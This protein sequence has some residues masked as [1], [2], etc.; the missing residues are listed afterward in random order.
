MNLPELLREHGVP[1]RNA[2]EHHHVT[3]GWLGADC[4]FCSPNSG[5]F[6]LGI[7]LD[8]LRCSCWSC[9]WHPT[10]P[11]LAEL[12]GLP[13]H[14][15]RGM[16]EGLDTPRREEEVHGKLVLPEG[17]GALLPAHRDYLAGRGIDPDDAGD[18][19]GCR[20]LGIAPRLQWRVWIP[21]R[22]RGKTAS[23][24]TRSIAENPKLRYV[25][26]R[27]EQES[28]SL[29]S[30]LLGEE[31]CSHAILVVE[32]PLDAMILGPGAVSTS[33]LTITRAQVNRMAKYPVRVI[34]LDAEPV[35]Q[36]VARKLCRALGA[37]PGQ[38]FNICLESGKDPGSCS[39]R[40]RREI[41]RRFL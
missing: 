13:F 5:H 10:I 9:G 21:A 26:A 20:G 14:Q 2:S 41:Q 23:W 12:T 35:A 38:T 17:L 16:L 6:R 19:W 18:R 30:L 27:P 25:S 39:R 24:T 31:H 33:G 28:L 36:R 29:K 4:P 8:D 15:L 37:F 32:G 22:S 7:K 40:E 11:T 3:H 1:F 34:C